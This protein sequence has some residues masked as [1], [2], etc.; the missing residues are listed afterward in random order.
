V[1][2]ILDEV[3]NE[4]KYE[5]RLVLFR[6]VLPKI[7]VFAIIIAILMIL[8]TW[9]Q[10]KIH[11][12]NQKTGDL[13]LQLLSSNNS[14]QNMVDS[15]LETMIDS[16]N[17]RQSELASIKL[18]SNKIA[19]NDLEGALENLE[20]IIDNKNFYS[21]TTAYARILWV[22]L[23]LDK[24]EI[25]ENEQIKARNYLQYFSNE[26]QEFYAMALLLKAFLYN[27]NNQIDL[28]KEF[29][30]NILK[31]DKASPIIKEQA[32]ALLSVM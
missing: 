25:A 22:S 3:L 11:D 20:K 30:Q 10:N 7:I 18:I 32:K 17:N 29:A 13:F 21:L 27:K 24:Q 19:A 8:Y 28:A 23:I 31:I 1:S 12:H 26:N 4:E 15:S 9:Q 5:K 16:T 2:D 6:K 14:D